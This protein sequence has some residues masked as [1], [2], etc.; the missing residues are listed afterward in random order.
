MGNIRFVKHMAKYWFFKMA[1]GNFG[2][3]RVFSF[4]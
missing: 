1:A 2:W 3:N 4:S